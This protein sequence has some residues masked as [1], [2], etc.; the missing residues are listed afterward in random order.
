MVARCTEGGEAGAAG[1]CCDHC[2]L[3]MGYGQKRKLVTKAVTMLAHCKMTA[4]R[5][6]LPRHRLPPKLLDFPKLK[7]R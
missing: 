5:L 2:V 3:A 1:K 4:Y 6:F 7:P